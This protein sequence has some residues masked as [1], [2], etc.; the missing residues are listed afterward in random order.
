LLFEN[1]GQEVEWDQYIVGPP[2]QKLGDRSLPV[3][4]GVWVVAPMDSDISRTGRLKTREWKWQH[5]SAG[6]E[7]A[8][9]EIVAPEGRGGKRGRNE[10]GKPNSRSLTLLSSRALD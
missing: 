3:P 4:M 8:G 7:K 5:H 10:Y 2:T 9:M 6:V 1:Y